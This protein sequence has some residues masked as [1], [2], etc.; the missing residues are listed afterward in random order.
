MVHHE[1]R[2]YNSVVL[3]ELSEEV[4]L[5]C[6]ES[7][8]VGIRTLGVQLQS[9]LYGVSDRDAFLDEAHRHLDHMHAV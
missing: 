6:L 8:L 2:K 5:H 7:F 1:G 3:R 4:F 9:H